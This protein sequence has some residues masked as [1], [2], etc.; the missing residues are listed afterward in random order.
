MTAGLF[1]LPLMLKA[2]VN[3]GSP[4]PPHSFSILELST[5]LMEGGLRMP[6]L[7]TVERNKLDVTSSEAK[8][9]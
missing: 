4:D 6:Q 2:Q 7:S 5:K 3:M 9:L 8:G 1:A